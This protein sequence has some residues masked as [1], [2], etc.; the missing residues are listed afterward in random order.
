L[1]VADGTNSHHFNYYSHYPYD[2]IRIMNLT[3]TPHHYSYYRGGTGERGGEFIHKLCSVV[4]MSEGTLSIR[5][6]DTIGFIHS[7]QHHL[8]THWHPS[9]CGPLA[10]SCEEYI[11][12]KNS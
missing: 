10:Y 3:L 4:I 2:S 12:H 1:I 5:N 7:H 6:E 11:L 8:P 9:K